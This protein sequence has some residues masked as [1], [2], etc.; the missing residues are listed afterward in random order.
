MILK[1][2]EN[3]RVELLKL[4]LNLSQTRARERENFA[5]ELKSSYFRDCYFQQ[6][7]VSASG[8]TPQMRLK[9]MTVASETA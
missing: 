9:F 5:A 7:F 2:Y 3:V 1:R 4:T 8:E 6:L